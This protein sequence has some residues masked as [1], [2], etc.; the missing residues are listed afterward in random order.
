[1]T[2]ENR[3][4]KCCYAKIDEKAGKGGWEKRRKYIV[5]DGFSP[6]HDYTV[7]PRYNEDP[8]MKKNFESPA[9]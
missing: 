4:S 7:E 3:L 2:I 5:Q 1:M 6:L 8:V 9:D